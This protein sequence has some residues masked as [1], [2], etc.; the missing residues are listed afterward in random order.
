[1][2]C[3]EYYREAY[4]I[5]SYVG[6]VGMSQVMLTYFVG[7]VGISLVMLTYWVDDIGNVDMLCEYVML[8]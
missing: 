5:I 4:T 2:S 1:M 3:V 8:I 7:D 6:Y